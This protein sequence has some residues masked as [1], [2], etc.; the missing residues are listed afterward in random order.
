MRYI[1]PQKDNYDNGENIYKDN[2]MALALKK[3]K[4]ICTKYKWLAKAPEEQ[5][6]LALSVELVNMKDSNLKFVKVSK[7]KGTQK[8]NINKKVDQKGSNKNHPNQN[9][10]DEYA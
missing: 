5:H 9:N 1:Q 6:I 2:L 4:T 10:D 7:A 8:G 3:Y